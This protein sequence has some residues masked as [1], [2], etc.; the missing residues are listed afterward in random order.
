MTLLTLMHLYTYLFILWRTHIY[1]FYDREIYKCPQDM[2]L[3]IN[4]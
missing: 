1:T 3:L 2:E 4:I